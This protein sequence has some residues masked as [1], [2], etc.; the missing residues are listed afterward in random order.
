[1]KITFLGTGSGAP[2]RHRN[3]SAFALQRPQQSGAWLFDCGEG[4]QH[5]ILRSELRLSQIDRIFISHMHGDH[6]FGLPGLL[7]SRSLQAGM[8]TP[9]TVYGPPGLHDYLR[10]TFEISQS[11]PAYPLHVVPVT[12]GLVFEDARTQVTCAAVS[13]RTPAFAYAVIERDSPGHFDVARAKELGIPSGPTYGRLKAGE[14]VT[15]ADGRV[16]DGAALTGP[17][18]RGRRLVYSG[19]TGYT[20][21]MVELARGA[22]VLI[23]EATFL[24]EDAAHADRASH[25]TAASA[26]K[27]AKQAGVETLILTH[28]SARYEGDGNR[29][30]DLLAEARAIFPNTILARDLWSYEVAGG[31]GSG[32]LGVEMG[33][34]E[35]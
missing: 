23:H 29:L 1:M 35:T 4:T 33:G 2:S 19:D 31:D 3:V 10:G 32:D 34:G 17:T 7:A 11:R 18:R 21:S 14:K 13:H 25:S 28:V 16:I 15:L 12:P 30:A 20:R 9:V 26:A 6:V 24:D 5:Q 8:Q 27:V 22:S